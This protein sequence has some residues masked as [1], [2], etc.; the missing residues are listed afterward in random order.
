M[1]QRPFSPKQSS[2]RRD[3][4][5]FR[6]VLV[7]L[8][9]AGALWWESRNRQG[10]PQIAPQD[11]PD[12]VPVVSIDTGG[13]E[14]P[15]ALPE[16]VVVPVPAPVSRERP[17]RVAEA[18][19]AKA[20]PPPAPAKASTSSTKVNGYDRLEGCRVEPHRNNDGDSF[21]VRHGQRVFELRLYFVDT[22]EKYLSDRHE[23]QRERVAQQARDF[24]GLSLDQT[25]MLGQ[26]AKAHTMSLLEGRAFTVFTKWER[27]YDG[28]RYYGFVVLPGRE[29][30]LSE[31]LVS[32]GLVRIHTKGQPSPDGLSTKQFEANLRALEKEAK[33]KRRGAWGLR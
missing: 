32:Q 5:L 27:V 23:S 16:P 7:F 1:R 28:E 30:Y 19:V 17:P 26:Q 3:G 22:A 14:S 8:L 18:P 12:L 25:V 10:V 2:P 24:G 29:D 21:M 6:Y 20:V 33:A 31:E 9:V 11:E 15:V 13:A 4:R